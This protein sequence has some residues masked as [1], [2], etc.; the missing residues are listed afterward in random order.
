MYLFLLYSI[1]TILINNKNVDKTDRIK[2]DMLRLTFVF[3][4][5]IVRNKMCRGDGEEYRTESGVNIFSSRCLLDFIEFSFSV[6]LSA[7]FGFNVEQHSSVC[8]CVHISTTY[9]NMQYFD[10]FQNSDGINANHVFQD[11]NNT[12]QFADFPKKLMFSHGCDI[13]T[14]FIICII[15]ILTLSSYLVSSVLTT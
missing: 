11:I 12:C 3:R 10:Y 8:V 5:D 1:C 6:V 7:I 15:T 2:F 14:C 4:Y 13:P 9:V